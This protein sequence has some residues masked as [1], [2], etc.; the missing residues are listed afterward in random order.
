M[1]HWNYLFIK[2]VSKTKKYDTKYSW[3]VKDECEYNAKL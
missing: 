2:R 3:K 1:C